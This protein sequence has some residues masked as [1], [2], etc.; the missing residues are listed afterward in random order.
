MNNPWKNFTKQAPFIADIDK[1]FV[2]SYNR[3]VAPEYKLQ[4]GVMPAPF[5]GGLDAARVV[6]LSLNP[7]YDENDNLRS[8]EYRT[9]IRENLDDPY[10]YNNFVYLDKRF[11]TLK[12]GT[13]VISDPGYDW[14][15][16]KTHWLMQNGQSIGGRFM[17]LEWFPYASKRF[18]AASQIFPSQRYTFE[19]LREAMRRNKMIVIL[20]GRAKWL[21]SV[22]ELATYGN[23]LELRSPQNVCVSPNN[24]KDDRFMEILKAIN[25]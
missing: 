3:N 14:W 2:E 10:G 1:E 18:K 25:S 15:M 13:S 20:R 17:A 9:A 16:S 6:F 7:G 19:I 23:L 4:T 12:K 22:P 21:E 5:N 8:E 11:S 24:V